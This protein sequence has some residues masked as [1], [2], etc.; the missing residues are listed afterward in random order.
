MI[1]VGFS[2]F[3]PYLMAMFVIFFVR[4]PKPRQQGTQLLITGGQH[5]DNAGWLSVK[6][7]TL[8]M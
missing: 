8:T 6:E 2:W 7:F 3:A 5:R 1:K 4:K